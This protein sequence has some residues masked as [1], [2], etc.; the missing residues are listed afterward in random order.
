[1]IN[2]IILIKEKLWKLQKIFSMILKI[3]QIKCGFELNKHFK[4][5][6]TASVQMKS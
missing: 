6:M 3:V 1:M 4:D 2:K 5:L